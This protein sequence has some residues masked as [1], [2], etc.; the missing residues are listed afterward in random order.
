MGISCSTPISTLR[1]H[2]FEFC[3]SNVTSSREENTLVRILL[4]HEEH[5]CHVVGVT[6]DSAVLW[7]PI[8]ATLCNI[9]I[10]G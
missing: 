5:A 7:H 6:I 1:A 9:S 3:A 4:R 2:A 8:D 10:I